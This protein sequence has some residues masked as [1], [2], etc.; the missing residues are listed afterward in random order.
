MTSWRN[1]K[2]GFCNAEGVEQG[3][4][5]A[6]AGRGVGNGG[7]SGT[8]K[9]CGEIREVKCNKMG[10]K[11]SVWGDEERYGWE[12]EGRIGSVGFVGPGR[13]RIPTPCGTYLQ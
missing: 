1:L 9:A 4:K 6:L 5:V 8:W 11:R 12:G 10:V 7:V 3:A 13:G 2:G